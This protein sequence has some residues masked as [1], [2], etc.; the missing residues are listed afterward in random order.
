[1]LEML[2]GKQ[3]LFKIGMTRIEATGI[4]LNESSFKLLVGFF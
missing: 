3:N 1:M 4:L 2:I